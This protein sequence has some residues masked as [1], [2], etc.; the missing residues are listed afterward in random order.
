MTNH[1]QDVAKMLGVELNE[2]FK[3]NNGEDYIY[4][5]DKFGLHCSE[6]FVDCKHTLLQLLNG[7]H[8]IK[9]APYKPK[10]EDIYYFLDQNGDADS[11]YWNDN[12][13]D[14]CLYKLGNCYRTAQEAEANRDKWIAFYASDEVLDI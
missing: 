8:S 3:I 2:K 13:V 11:S 14:I 1:M 7:V 5:F 10:T 4:Y 9:H 12:F 6:C